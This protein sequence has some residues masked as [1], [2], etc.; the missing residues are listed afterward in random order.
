MDETSAM[1]KGLTEE[2]REKVDRLIAIL[3]THAR[4]HRRLLEILRAKRSAT[5]DAR[6]D[7]LDGI[8]ESERIAFEAVAASERQRLAQAVEIGE[9]LGFGRGRRVR[10]LDLIGL[11]GEDHQEVL[12]DLRDDLRDIADAIDDAIRLNR[13][14]VLHSLDN[15]HLFLSRDRA[16]GPAIHSL[17]GGRRD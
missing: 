8:I 7:E 13:T 15:V 3:E 5:I 4:L 17:A 2:I 9:S 11:V 16:K 14:L 12:L 1:G 6:V 10:L